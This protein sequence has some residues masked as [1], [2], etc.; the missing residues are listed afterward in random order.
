VAVNLCDQ[1]AGVQ[2]EVD[3]VQTRIHLR[4]YVWRYMGTYTCPPGIEYFDEYFAFRDLFA[5]S[6]WTIVDAYEALPN[7]ARATAVIREC[8]VGEDCNCTLWDGIPGRT[9]ESCM[10]DCMCQWPLGCVWEGQTPPLGG[11]WCY[12]T[13]SVDADC[14]P[15][16]K[17]VFN[18]EDIPEGICEFARDE[19][20][21]DQDCQPGFTCQYVSDP[22][23]RGEFCLPNMSTTEVGETCADDCDCS[24]GLS[25]VVTDDIGMRSCQIKC[26]GDWD[27]PGEMCCDAGDLGWT[28]NLLRCDYCYFW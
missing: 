26:R 21:G 3:T 23:G 4:A 24:D 15:P 22:D 20:A 2:S 10:Y 19:C 7:P 8:M 11:G 1:L 25:C 16:H 17:C 5:G 27:C 28:D 18:Y 12:K 9:G 14:P 13:C 6:P